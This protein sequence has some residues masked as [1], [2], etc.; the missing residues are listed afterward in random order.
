MKKV[1]LFLL[2]FGAGLT[3]LVWVVG[4]DAPKEDVAPKE[5]PAPPTNFTEVPGAPT[6]PGEQRAAVGIVLDGR[7]DFTVFT[8]D[9]PE[10]GRPLYQVHS[11][12]LKALGGDLYDAHELTIAVHD[13][14]TKKLRFELSSPVTQLHIPIQQGKFTIGDGEKVDFSSVRMTM[15]E[16]APIVPLSL[17]TPKLTWHLVQGRLVDRIDSQD[18]VQFDGN[19]FTRKARASISAAK[20]AEPRSRTTARWCSHATDSCVCVSNAA[21][22]RR[23]ARRGADRSA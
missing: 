21:A 23:C 20:R 17:S 1:V 10:Q 4:K 22:K 19:G 5:K 7:T 16:G 2:L 15:H 3:V 6:K 11:D 18:R 13:P 12:D 14:E 8:S 9:D